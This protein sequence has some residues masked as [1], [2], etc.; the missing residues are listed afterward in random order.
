MLKKKV[1]KRFDFILSFVREIAY[2]YI[3]RQL[4]TN[5]YLWFKHL[6]KL[7]METESM[8]QE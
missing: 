4:Y 6:I 2:T 5:K 7:F 8:E 3:H 1:Y